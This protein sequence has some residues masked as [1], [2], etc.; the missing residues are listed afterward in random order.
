MFT[1][2][3]IIPLKEYSTFGTAEYLSLFS[4]K[5]KVSLIFNYPESDSH[6]TPISRNNYQIRLYQHATIHNNYSNVKNIPDISQ[7]VRYK[8]FSGYNYYNI[9]RYLAYFINKLIHNT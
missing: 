2:L 6:I 4:L 5:S 3:N 1:S 7:N 8:W 9:I